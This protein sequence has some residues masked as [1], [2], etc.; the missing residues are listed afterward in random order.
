MSHTLFIAGYANVR[1]AL[2][3]N[4]VRQ[5]VRLPALS[6]VDELPSWVRGVF[7][8]HGEVLPVLDL[9]L[10]FGRRHDALAT[11]H[12]VVVVEQGAHQLG[13]LVH[14][15]YDV[16]TLATDAIDA[17]AQY[18]LPGGSSRFVSGVAMLDDGIAMLL[19]LPALLNEA[20]EFPAPAFVDQSALAPSDEPSDLI[21]HTRA[22]SLAKVPAAAV[23]GACHP[24][25]LF[26][27][28][29][30]L[31]G[32]DAKV[33]SEFMHRRGMVPIPGKPAYAA[34][35][36]NRRGEILT[37]IDIR[38]LL[39]ADT[40]ADAPEVIVLTH[41]GMSFGI[42]AEKSEDVV[43][44]ADQAIRATAGQESVCLRTAE[45]EGHVARLIDIDQL[46]STLL[47]AELATHA[48]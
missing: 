35:V 30:E 12:W 19:D 34:G 21:F 4:M 27:I 16:V 38:S 47:P 10:R 33:V 39:K 25:V 14:E 13:I 5:A 36:I 7:S 28:G 41:R 32:L 37:V 1:Y 42:L 43:D 9:G 18:Q 8:L 24:Y 6:E 44:I 40:L 48:G 45:I 26:Y 17:A 15:I 31:F 2:D 23:A 29:G 20:A 46:V 11:Q 22:V 3:A